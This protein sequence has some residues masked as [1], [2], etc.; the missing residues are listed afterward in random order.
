MVLGKDSGYLH[1]G[2]VDDT[3]TPLKGRLLMRADSVHVRAPAPSTASARHG[4]FPWRGISWRFGCSLLFSILIMVVL[5]SYA[6]RESLGTWDRRL[7]NMLTILF[8]SLVSLSMGSLLGLLGAVLRWPLLARRAHAPRDADLILGMP[9]PTGSLKLIV[10]HCGRS[11]TWSVTTWTV[12]A[13][14]LVN[15]IGRL[16]VATFG[17][18]Y[19]LNENAKVDYPVM[20]HDFGIRDWM[21]LDTSDLNLGKYC[22]DHPGAGGCYP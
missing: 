1:S 14:L 15:I 13:Y 16:S 8:S 11:G 22:P 9:N 6:G 2:D 19:D 7:F 12:L 4:R 10:H 18:T 17:L 3:G 20:L 21:Q 5:Y